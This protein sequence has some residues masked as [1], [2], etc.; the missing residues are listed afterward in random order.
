[1]S[2]FLRNVN[3]QTARGFAYSF[4]SRIHQGKSGSYRKYFN[5]DNGKIL[6]NMIMVGVL[7]SY[8]HKNI[9]ACIEDE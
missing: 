2:G 5:N 8:Y 6:R 3:K 1:M 7:S 9:I 4:S